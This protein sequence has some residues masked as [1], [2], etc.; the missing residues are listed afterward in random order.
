MKVSR[1]FAEDAQAFLLVCGLIRLGRAIAHVIGQKGMRE[2]KGSEIRRGYVDFFREKGHEIMP[3]ASLVPREDASLLWI[4]SGMAPLKKYFDGRVVPDNPRLTNSQKCIR[5]NDIEN[6]GKTAR[7]HTFFE[8]LGNFSIGD[9]FKREAIHWAWEFLTERL[10]LD[11]AR[12]SITIHPEDDEAFSVWH[13]E[14]GVPEV[15]I[16]RLEDN[17]WDIG[18][19][20]C[21]PNSE[22]FYDRGAHIGCGRP[23]CDASCDC[24]RHLEIWNLV[25]S[26]YN[27]NPD[28][29]YT[30]LPKKNI[31]TG[32]GL[33]R[34]ALV[35]QNAETNYDTDLIKPLVD[36][37]VREMGI[38]YGAT[39]EGDVALKVVADH[40]R[41]IAFAI[42]DGVL[43]GNEGR[44]Y[45]IRRLLR[46]AVRY[47]R[48]FGVNR[49][50][51][52]KIVGVVGDI[53]GD[54][55]PEVVEKRAFIEDI[56]RAEEERF[57]ETLAEGETLLSQAIARV[58]ASGSGVLPGAQAFKLYDTYGFPVDLTEEIAAE[59]G[60]SVD[61][62]GFEREL[63]AQRVRARSAR[64]EADSMQV[65]VVALRE[66]EVASRFVGYDRD[67]AQA[68]VAAIVA[69]HEIAQQAALGEH[70][71]LVLD[72]TPFYAESGGQVADTGV[73]SGDG[74]ELRVTD[75]QKGPNGQNVHKCEVVM[76]EV[77]V[78]AG[79]TARIDVVRRRDIAQNHTATHLLHKALREVLGAHVAQAGSLVEP[80]R[81][82]FDFSHHGTISREELDRVERMVNQE[83]WRDD[84][85]AIEEM[86]QDA[87]RSLGAMALFGEKYG[88]I[89]RVVRVGEY[90]M[91]LCGG[92]HVQRTGQIHLF[93]LVTETGI[94]SGVRRVEAVCGAHAYAFVK[95][96]ERL[97]LAV[98]EQLRSAPAG[99][100][101]RV[102]GML[103]RVRE[104]EREVGRL[105]AELSSSEAESLLD[106][107]EEMPGGALV[108]AQIKGMDATGLRV[109]ADRLR[110]KSA[111]AL[112]V[113]GSVKDGRVSFVASLPPALV[114]KGGHAGR[115][116]KEIAQIAGGSGGGRPDIAQAGAKDPARVA[117]ALHTARSLARRLLEA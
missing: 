34:T 68:H 103:D 90:S 15:R 8:M 2:M 57:H 25:F 4:N 107:A 44:H 61:R 70:I 101:G 75:V 106:Q 112:V 58:K 74:F 52:H 79:V 109:V 17:F 43:P 10:S 96:E 5:T 77:R 28:G 67:E 60:I 97:L 13:K 31:D 46:R 45:V 19:G 9:Y 91:E 113:L 84:S 83:I 66:L 51:L 94:G 93:R 22:I 88:E 53:M 27:H 7:H 50:F 18:E 12:L 73:I 63:D 24:D 76:G 92:C 56:V 69:G 64:Q 32:M 6:V 36:A 41:T 33:E 47:G 115:L 16:L 3:S 80:E 20:P 72:Q 38:E 78:G 37:A 62:D 117:D 29:S 35:L 1:P 85:V 89:V 108:V 116:V 102:D 26:Q 100:P 59:E 42:G 110:E 81:L 54:Y 65:Q 23:E 30:P 82:R 11:S 86:A 71:L 55:Y 95:A 105:T 114:A 14:I 111:D 104:L 48:R 99:L 21:G 87:A 98:S 39:P 49:P 40:L